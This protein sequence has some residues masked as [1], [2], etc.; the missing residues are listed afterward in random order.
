[1]Q[2]ICLFI[3][4]LCL[5]ISTIHINIISNMKIRGE[6]SFIYKS[7]RVQIYLI[8]EQVNRVRFYGNL[9]DATKW[10]YRLTKTWCFIIKLLPKPVF[11]T[12][13]ERQN[14]HKFGCLFKQAENFLVI[15]NSIIEPYILRAI[16]SVRIFFVFASTCNLFRWIFIT[17]TVGWNSASGWTCCAMWCKG[18]GLNL[19]KTRSAGQV[20][21]GMGRIANPKTTQCAL[22]NKWRERAWLSMLEIYARTPAVYAYTYIQGARRAQISSLNTLNINWRLKSSGREAAACYFMNSLERAKNT[23]THPGAL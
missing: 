10:S 3:L 16:F 18:V 4:H 7:T 8:L 23:L 19:N 6:Q 22:R 1:M 20:C 9:L 13:Q 11:G 5:L 15:H 12:C 21:V 17:H 14:T 2:R